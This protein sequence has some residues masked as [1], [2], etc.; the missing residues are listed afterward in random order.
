MHGHPGDGLYKTLRDMLG[1]RAPTKHAVHTAT[2]GL[3]LP[4]VADI[5]RELNMAYAGGPRSNRADPWRTAQRL[6]ETTRNR[7]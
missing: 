6:I 2:D 7:R 1:D 4:E 3:T 5:V